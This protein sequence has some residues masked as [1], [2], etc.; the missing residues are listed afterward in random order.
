MKCDRCHF[1]LVPSEGPKDARVAFV[2]QNPGKNEYRWRNEYGVGRPFVGKTGYILRRL[3]AQV[4]FDVS[5]DLDANLPLEGL[6]GIYLTNASRCECP[7]DRTKLLRE[8]RELEHLELVVPLGSPAWKTVSGEQKGITQAA[9]HLTWVENLGW[10]LPAGHPAQILY[11]DEKVEGPSVVISLYVDLYYILRNARRLLDEGPPAAWH[12]DY[13]VIR[14]RKDFIRLYAKLCRQELIGYDLETSST[15]WWEGEA[16]VLALAWS[17]TEA[18]IVPFSLLRQDGIPDYLRRIFRRD[19][20]F[21]AHHAKF[22]DIFFLEELGIAPPKPD[23]TMLLEYVLD[24]RPYKGHLDLK[25]LAVREFMVQDW[26]IPFQAALKRA[27]KGA[28]YLDVS[29]TDLHDYAARDTAATVWLY[30]ELRRRLSEDQEPLYE[31]LKEASTMF[32]VL[33]RRG[34]YL[35]LEWGKEIKQDLL[36]EA[37]TVR[38]ALIQ[39]IEEQTGRD[40]KDLNPRSPPQLSKILFDE[41]GY[42]P[43]KFSPKTGNPSTDRDTLEHLEQR[44]PRNPLWELIRQHRS[45]TKMHGTYVRPYLEQAVVVA[46]GLGKVFIDTS[47]T[48]TETGRLSTSKGKS[49][50]IMVYPHK[51]RKLI[52]AGPPHYAPNSPQSDCLFFSIDFS[53]LEFVIAAILS[54]CEY[55]LEL[56]R[57]GHL[58]HAAAARLAWGEGYSKTQYTQTKN[59]NFGYIFTVEHSVMAGAAAGM[60]SSGLYKIQKLYD[61]RMPEFKT[62]TEGIRQEMLERGYLQNP[63]GRRRRFHFLNE[64]VALKGSG[65]LNEALKEGINFLTQSTGSDIMLSGMIKA[66][67]ELDENNKLSLRFCVHDEIDGYI[68][69]SQ[70]RNLLALWDLLEEHATGVFNGIVP[71]HCE[72]SVGP[73]WGE[74]TEYSSKDEFLEVL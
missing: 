39:T 32:R 6:G 43:L 15:K 37:G 70:A 52:C 25:D 13:E 35:D 29:E 33:D 40:H 57:Q 10:V 31:M 59:M 47:L 65:F 51:L 2:G 22:D 61:E 30:S 9:G 7:P 64:L 28:T 14:T 34:I 36:Q 72:L 60:S 48:S 44:D 5:L 11:V 17:P 46:K 66:F 18:A 54:K 71:I 41:L 74:L 8:L 67:H 49:L 16:G 4:G 27:G 3:L 26:D 20:R 55:A 68:L 1:P 42:I 56:M 38:A 23:D 45:A 62:W 53:Q 58:F 69:K 12:V 24:E 19:I 63:F 50:A 21:V 73:S